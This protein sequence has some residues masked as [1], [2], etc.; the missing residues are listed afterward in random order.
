MTSPPGKGATDDGRSLSRRGLLAAAGS[1][2]ALPVTARTTSAHRQSV[3]LTVKLYPGPMPFYAWFQNGLVGIGSGWSSIYREMAESVRVAMETLAAYAEHHSRVE[4]VDSRVEMR[5]PIEDPSLER[6]LPWVGEVDPLSR[7]AVVERFRER[8]HERGE[9]EGSCCHQLLWWDPLNHDLGYG[10]VRQ[11]NDHVCQTAD[12]GAQVVANVGATERW[13]SRAVSRNIAIH[14][15]LHAFLSPDAV[16]DVVGSDCEHDL[17]TAVRVDSETLRV[18]PIA[19][20][21]AGPGIPGRGTRWHGSGCYDHEEFYRHDG[22]DGIER[23][24]YTPELSR[25]VLDAVALYVE[26]S[27]SRDG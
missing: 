20:A 4:S 10:A 2:G 15:A 7:K 27:L 13:D 21:Y 11:P 14:E 22:T 25:G 12:E 9:V 24:E 8:V 16:E 3:T 18:S 1:V 17:G 26:R 19:T 23:W 5:A 6:A